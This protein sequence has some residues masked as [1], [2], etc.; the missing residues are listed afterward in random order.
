MQF[1]GP[2][3]LMG[4]LNCVLNLDER[5]GSPVRLGEIREI[6]YCMEE[7]GLSDIPYKGNFYTWCNK[8]L[9]DSRVYSR[10]DR[11]MANDEWQ[12]AYGCMIAQ[13]LNADIS[14]HCPAFVSTN[15]QCQGRKPFKF[16]RVWSTAANFKDELKKI[17]GTYVA[18]SRMFRVVKKLK[19]VKKW[20][21]D[22]NQKGFYELQKQAT[23]AH[24][25][26]ESIQTKLQLDPLNVQ[27][28]YEEQEA[29]KDYVV[30]Q[31][32]YVSFLK[33]KAKLDWVREGD[34]NTKIFHQSIK[35]RRLQNTIH[36]IQD[37]NG[38]TRE[39]LKGIADAF[40]DYYKQLLGGHMLRFPVQAQFMGGTR[41][42]ADQIH[43]LSLPFTRK[44]VKSAMFSIYGD[45]AP[46]LDGFG[47]FFFRDHWVIVG[48][49]IEEA[50]LDVLNSGKLLK[51]LNHTLLSLIPKSSCPTS[52]TEFRPISCCNTLYKCITKVLCSRLKIVL[53]S[54]ISLNQGAFVQD[55]YIV[56]N[57][58]VCQDLI[59]HYGRRIDQVA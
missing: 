55:R 46:S 35:K 11:V 54:L 24:Q 5:L 10:I 18:G 59:R 30:K 22:L 29:Q 33:Q 15:F 43:V 8:H 50:M 37:I 49:S 12:E 25:L 9:D 48:E 57:I 41:L 52:V 58:L 44:E 4:D 53:P 17:W 23:M 34:E 20:L 6:R 7:C 36:S 39:G 31:G 16:Y 21:K 51:E 14:D 56:H 28:M 40:L 27:L 32:A 42:S 3:L 1:Q 2:W 45:K 47:S 19:L 13:F 38:D 26:L